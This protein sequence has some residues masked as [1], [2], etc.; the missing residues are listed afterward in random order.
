MSGSTQSD[1][2][3]PG[4][5]GWKLDHKT[6]EFEINSARLQVGS[7]PVDPQL[8]IITAGEWSDCD[9]PSNAIE[10][11]KFIGNQVMKISDEYRDSAEFSNE[12]FSFD[13]DGSDYRTTLTYKRLETAEEVVARQ[14]KAKVAGTRLS[15]VGGVLTVTHDGVTRLQVGNLEKTEQSEP[16]I[17]VDGV[18][19][20]NEAVI[21]EATLDSRLSPN[22]TLRVQEG[23]NGPYAAG[24]GMGLSSQFIVSADRFAVNG[25]NASD[26]LR[27]IAGKI[28]ET[29][30]GQQ[31]KEQIEQSTLAM[32]D[33]VKD[34][35]RTELQPGGLLHRSR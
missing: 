19:Y 17:V 32:A 22:W 3:V 20:I 33:Q 2:Y 10:R 9:L 35:I 28:G 30:L 1:N 18:T 11:Y 7:L 12:D 8:I 15:L 26:I 24:I 34:V 5:S 21:K 25:R 4:M 29:S 14:K 23:V 27:D 31:L 6:G 16:F 13:C